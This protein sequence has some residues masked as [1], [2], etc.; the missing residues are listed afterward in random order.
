M[1]EIRA[2]A[3]VEAMS[4]NTI[5]APVTILGCLPVIATVNW[6]EDS[7]DVWN[8][9]WRKKDGTAGKEISQHMMDKAE[10]YDFL[11]CDLCEQVSEWHALQKY[12]K[13]ESVT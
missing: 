4:G 9:F 10:K 11:L 2:V 3:G 12:L 6:H 13:K 5:T 8:I 1:A 7:A